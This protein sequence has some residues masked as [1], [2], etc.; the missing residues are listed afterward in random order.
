M[1][2]DVGFDVYGQ[3][4]GNGELEGKCRVKSE[5][6]PNHYLC[7]IDYAADKGLYEVHL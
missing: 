7:S 2:D 5:T 6:L 1:G 3:G 4:G